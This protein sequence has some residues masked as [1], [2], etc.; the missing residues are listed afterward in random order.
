MKPK[1]TKLGICATSI[2]LVCAVL[3]CLGDDDDEELDAKMTSDEVNA[4]ISIAANVNMY[5]LSETQ[6]Q[7]TIEITDDTSNTLLKQKQSANASALKYSVT[8]FDVDYKYEYIKQGNV[9]NIYT[10]ETWLYGRDEVPNFVNPVYLAE[11]HFLE[12]DYDDNDTA[13]DTR[14][15]TMTGQK[16]GSTFTNLA[17]HTANGTTTK[18]NIQDSP[19]RLLRVTNI[20][21]DDF[22]TKVT[23]ITKYNYGTNVNIAPSTG[24]D[25]TSADV[26]FESSTTKIP[27]ATWSIPEI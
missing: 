9:I 8:F 3:G 5:N 18:L 17:T 10:N 4:F 12:L 13:M 23:T 2:I 19:R 22:G 21:T 27:M 25:K 16:L 7:L 14:E 6:D 1:M 20:T 26:R 11:E 15:W 24:Y